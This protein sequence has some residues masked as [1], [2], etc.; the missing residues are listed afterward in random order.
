MLNT[1][2]LLDHDSVDCTGSWILIRSRKGFQWRCPGCLRAYPATLDS[3]YGVFRERA[4]TELMKT[5]CR[6]GRVMRERD[7]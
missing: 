2:T 3:A 1:A 5:L 6:E 7:T 4:L